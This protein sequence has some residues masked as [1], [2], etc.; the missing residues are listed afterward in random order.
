LGY[1]D[2]SSPPTWLD[3]ANKYNDILFKK[4]D[5]AYRKKL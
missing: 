5:E 1:F 3:L 2:G 4:A